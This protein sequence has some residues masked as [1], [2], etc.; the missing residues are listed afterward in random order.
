MLILSSGVGLLPVN[1]L[2]NVMS[3]LLYSRA[4]LF[5]VPITI[6]AIISVT[7]TLHLPKTEASD[8][9]AKFKRVDWAGA[10]S[11]ILTVFLLL[12]ALDRGGN[13]SWN[14]P[15]TIYSLAAFPIFFTCFA[16][17]EMKFASEPFAPQRIIVNRALIASYLVNFFGMASAF[18]LIFYLPLY[19]QAVA[20]TNRFAGWSMAL[21]QRFW[22]FNWFSWWRIDHAS[23]WEIL[24]V[25]YHLIFCIAFGYR[26]RQFVYGY[27]RLFDHWYSSRQVFFFIFHLL[28]S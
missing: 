19:L 16:V 17:I 11:L 15:L 20:S 4:F 7:L 8:L 3:C 23:D 21:N 12:F 6:A 2:S 10:I 18:A 27:H 22:W 25:N 9:M 26:C 5:Q 28:T 1:C 14:D 24:P 13:V